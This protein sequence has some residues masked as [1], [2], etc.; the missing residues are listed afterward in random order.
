MSYLE[1]RQSGGMIDRRGFLQSAMAVA[2]LPPLGVL[3]AEPGSML[4]HKVV[5]DGRFTA[6]H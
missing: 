1:P 4:L 3:A 6:I 5:Y 2:A